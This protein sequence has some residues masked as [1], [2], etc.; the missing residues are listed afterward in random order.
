M[1]VPIESQASSLQSLILAGN[2]E[3]AQR[4][5][6]L[7]L[8]SELFEA[9]VKAGHGEA[10]IY[11]MRENFTSLRMVRDA[12]EIAINY[13]R[14]KV[15][16]HLLERADVANMPA[17]KPAEVTELLISV[18]TNRCCDTAKVL[19]EYPRFQPTVAVSQEIIE[20]L[21]NNFT[22][23]QT[24][25][26]INT[27]LGYHTG[28][29]VNIGRALIIAC[30]ERRISVLRALLDAHNTTF[31]DNSYVDAT[32]WTVYN[33][34]PVFLKLMLTKP[35]VNI[36]SGGFD[37][38]G[39]A[40]RGRYTECVQILL[41]DS[42]VDPMYSC[43][44]YCRAAISTMGWCDQI[45]F[46][47]FEHPKVIAALSDIAILNELTIKAIQIK[48]ITLVKHLCKVNT[49]SES[50][51]SVALKSDSQEI[52]DIFTQ[53]TRVNL[54]NPAILYGFIPKDVAGA[55]FAEHTKVVNQ[56]NLQLEASQLREAAQART[57]ERL[58]H[59][60]KVVMVA[61]ETE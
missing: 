8:N 23:D 7:S 37:L 26:M 12:I 4:V 59:Q 30:R 28:E 43:A 17:A 24:V 29:P 56:L 31:H 52:R 55:I 33:N 22:R 16:K 42:R 53:D 39:R 19:L 32:D 13:D 1:S 2:F 60:L 54:Q 57:I 40:V 48:H 49:P 46:E 50:V 6:K 5:L 47:I 14:P 10:A 21:A 58:E 34:D 61:L 18:A 45:V 38:L 27:F 20:K 25:E 51:I 44:G 35:Q 41:K 15:L 3:A 9:L 36:Y 11:A